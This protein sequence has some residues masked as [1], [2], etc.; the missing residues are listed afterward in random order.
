MSDERYPRG[1]SDEPIGGETAS[2]NDSCAEDAARAGRALLEEVRVLDNYEEAPGVWVIAL[3]SPRVASL[4]R[5]GQFVHLRL[6][7][8][9]AHILR[10]PISVYGTDAEAGFIELM[11]QVVGS[12]T[13]WMTKLEEGDVL[14]LIGPLGQGWRPPLC[15]RRALLVTGGLGAAPLTMLA[16]ELIDAGVE[17]ETVM[18]APTAQRLVCRERLEGDGR[19]MVQVATD[20]G[21][22]GLHGF[23]T[24]LAEERLQ[25]AHDGLIEPYDYIAVCGPA[26]MMRIVCATVARLAPQ[27]LCE[28]SLEKRMA[29]GIGACLSCVVETVDGLKRSCKDG[30]VFAAEEVV[31]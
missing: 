3:E 19:G 8:F 16:E 4:I 25:A 24:V 20:D 2:A 14:D 1:S 11:Y 29:C 13:D 26:P 17:V 31:W 23:S 22:E 10:R 28:I 15:A 5:P 21:S 12:G 9:E 6:T 7:G 30:P 27:A 18:G